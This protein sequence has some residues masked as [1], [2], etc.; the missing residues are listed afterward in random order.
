[1]LYSTIGP[2]AWGYQSTVVIPKLALLSSLQ[3]LHTL[4]VFHAH[5]HMT[6]AIK[7]S[8]QGV[9]FPK[10]HTLIIPEHCHE[11][12]K[13]CPHV[14]KVWCNRGSGSKLV[15]VIA[16]HCKEVQ[17]MRDFSADERLVKSA[18]VE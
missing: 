5:S 3:N 11:I 7:N 4:Q 2:S 14:T 15:M 18:C 16:Q 9:I 10:I 1:M 17:E 12:L 6:T 8:L 13:C